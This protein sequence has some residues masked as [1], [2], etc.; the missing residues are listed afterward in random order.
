MRYVN[1]AGFVVDWDG[2]PRDVRQAEQTL[3]WLLALPL[4][5]RGVEAMAEIENLSI[6][7]TLLLAELDRLR[8]A[9]TCRFRE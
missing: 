9:P 7:L 3:R 6:A 5:C 8:S 4:D 1:E 2:R